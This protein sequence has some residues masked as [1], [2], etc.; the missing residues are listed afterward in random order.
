MRTHLVP[1]V[2]LLTAGALGVRA[3]Q[4][5]DEGEEV[6]PQTVDEAQAEGN[7]NHQHYHGRPSG[8]SVNLTHYIS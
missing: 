7:H 6:T 4:G 2:S 8:L 3:A 5:D 1:V